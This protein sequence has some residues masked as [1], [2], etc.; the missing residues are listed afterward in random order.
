MNKCIVAVVALLVIAPLLGAQDPDDVKPQAPGTAEETAGKA[1][2]QQTCGFC[3]GPDG[4]GA[5]GTDLLH[6]SLVSH[7]VGGNLIGEVVRKGRPD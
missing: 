3:H 5:S 6:S 2:F 1:V 7:D 4:R